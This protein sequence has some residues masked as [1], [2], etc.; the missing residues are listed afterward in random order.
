ATAIYE[1]PPA[2]KLPHGNDT[3]TGFRLTE[4][5]KS[6]RS[7]AAYCCRAPPR[8]VPSPPRAPPTVL[9]ARAFFAPARARVSS[10]PCGGGQR[11]VFSKHRLLSS[12]APGGWESDPS[13]LDA[14]DHGP[15]A[16]R[17]AVSSQRRPVHF[18]A[19]A[20]HLR[21]GEPGPQQREGVRN[22]FFLIGK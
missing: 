4:R 9:L 20:C 7:N 3:F 13:C 14:T 11:V 6:V 5:P 10:L 17:T 18:E 22:R 21:H 19:R 15:I 16:P 1:A 12:N 2:T 8:R